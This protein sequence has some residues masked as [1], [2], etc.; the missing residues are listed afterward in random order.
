MDDDDD[1]IHDVFSS[2]HLWKGANLYE[3][4]ERYESSLFAPLQLDSRS[5]RV[6]HPNAFCI[7]IS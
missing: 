6:F 4:T 1:A 3:E 2:N 5:H 7:L